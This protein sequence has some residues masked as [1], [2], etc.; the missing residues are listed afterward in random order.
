M[1]DLIFLS[2]STVYVRVCFVPSL[3]RRLRLS[4]R[5]HKL[6]PRD[7]RGGGGGAQRHVRVVI[8][9][10]CDVSACVRVLVTGYDD[11]C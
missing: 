10:G 6:T 9:L 5:T 3:A 4:A 7:A 1:T 11:E 2:T 8:R